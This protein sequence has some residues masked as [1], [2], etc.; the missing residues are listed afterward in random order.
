MS[1]LVELLPELIVD[2]VAAADVVVVVVAVGGDVVVVAAAGVVVVVGFDGHYVAVLE[3]F[4][5]DLYHFGY[6]VCDV[7]ANDFVGD[8]DF[9][10]ELNFIFN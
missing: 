9:E 2:V 3:T 5:L 6:V 8:G 10:F 7:V 1:E 4:V